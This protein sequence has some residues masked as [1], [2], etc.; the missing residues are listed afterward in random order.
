MPY[1]PRAR[2]SWSQLQPNLQR[3]LI[4]PHACQVLHRRDLEAIAWPDGAAASTRGT[5]LSRWIQAAFITPVETKRQPYDLPIQKHAIF[6]LGPTGAGRLWEYGRYRAAPRAAP[7]TRVLPGMLLASHIAVA[8]ARDLH[9]EP[10]VTA[11]TWQCRPFTG[12]GVRPDGEGVIERSYASWPTGGITPV[13]ILALPAPRDFVP[14][15]GS[16]H[17]QLFLEVDMGTEERNQLVVR[18]QRWGA[19]YRELTTPAVPWLRSRVLWVVR[20]DRRRVN[21]I[22]RIWGQHAQC[23]LLIATVK[24]LTIDGVLHPWC[25]Q[26]S[27]ADGRPVSLRLHHG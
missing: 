20:G 27:D 25:G 24:D 19:R 8:L 7:K 13:D 23:P 12:E 4:W 22:R 11:F 10:G 6:T 5:A 9:A 17:D 3:V 1:P 26:W 2:L 21:S 14:P 16:M 15:R 18:S